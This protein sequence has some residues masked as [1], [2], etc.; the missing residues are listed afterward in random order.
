VAF[1][2]EPC[3]DQIEIEDLRL[4]VSAWQ[5][6][7]EQLSGIRML[8]QTPRYAISGRVLQSEPGWLKN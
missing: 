3:C 5:Q 6:Q 1:A 4:T 2:N 7:S 8:L